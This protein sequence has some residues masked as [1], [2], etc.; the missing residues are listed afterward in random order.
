M[1]LSGV[2]F[3]LGD[4]LVTQEPL[5]GSASNGLGA[6]ALAALLTDQV[7]HPPTAE[8]LAETLGEALHEALVTAYETECAAPDVRAV[9]REVFDGF[10]WEPADELLDQLVPVYFRPHFDAMQARPHVPRVLE[11]LRTGGLR[12]ALLANVLYGE[13]M[14]L[15]RLAQLRILTNLDAF[16]LSTQ[17]GWLKPHPA[18]YREAA[19]RLGLDASNLVMV[20]D[21]WDFDVRTPQR[22]GMRAIW[23][24]STG[25]TM[26]DSVAPDAIIDDLGDLLPSLAALEPRTRPA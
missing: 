11:L 12:V 6:A 24:R 1:A 9:F 21:D 4:T 19:A 8:Q 5:V 15:E 16:V 7:E 2:L 10:D 22:L 25:A 26:P 18:L 23:L 3:D 17:T 13:E 20:G 14:L